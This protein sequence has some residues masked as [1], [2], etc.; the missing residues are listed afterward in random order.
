MAQTLAGSAARR[1]GCPPARPGARSG[2]RARSSCGPAP[3][4]LRTP[5]NQ[6]GQVGVRAPHGVR[7]VAQAQLGRQLHLPRRD[8]HARAASVRHC[9]GGIPTRGHMAVRLRR[10]RE[11]APELHAMS[12]RPGSIQSASAQAAGQAG[13]AA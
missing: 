11:L 8:L 2:A 7:H 1:A 9:P 6:P 12:Q 3:G 5:A 4:A 13:Q 10:Q